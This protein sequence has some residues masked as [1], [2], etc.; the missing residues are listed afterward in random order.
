V[1]VKS[2]NKRSVVEETRFLWWAE[3]SGNFELAVIEYKR[4]VEPRR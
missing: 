1:E 2:G 4:S 3:S